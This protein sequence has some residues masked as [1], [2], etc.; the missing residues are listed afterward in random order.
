MVDGGDVGTAEATHGCD[1]ADVFDGHRRISHLGTAG[2][3]AF[4]IGRGQALLDGVERVG[5]AHV[6]AA[7][8]RQDV[9]HAG[10]AVIGFADHI[11]AEEDD[12]DD[13]YDATNNKM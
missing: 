5:V 9:L 10:S 1:G 13:Y 8:A 7:L 4:A 3:G 12:A 2:A 11:Q 6:V